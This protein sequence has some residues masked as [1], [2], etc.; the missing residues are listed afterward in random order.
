MNKIRVLIVDD[1]AVVRQVLTRELSK[2]PDIEVVGTAPDPYVA[3]DKIIQLLPDVLTLDIEMPRMDGLTFLRK[4]MRSKPIPTIVVSSLTPKGSDMAMDALDAG[5]VDVICKSG[6]AYSIGEVAATLIE[7]IR[8]AARVDATRLKALKESAMAVTKPLGALRKTTNQIFAIGA[9][10]GGTVAT[11]VLMRQLPSNSPGI[12]IVQHMPESFTRSYAERL[13]QLSAV[14]VREAK[15]GDRVIPGLAL[16]APGNF[17]MRLVRDGA[18]YAVKMDQETRLHYQRPAV[19]PLFDSVAE[20]AGSNCVAALLTG[21]GKDG[22][23]G[24]LRI[25]QAGGRTIAQD[26]NSSVVWGMPGEAVRLGAADFV[27]PLDQIA[28]KALSL[29]EKNSSFSE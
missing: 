26:E 1:S 20:V 17:H 22:A 19:D 3:R 18:V 21:M 8:A 10:T 15:N 6:A 7:Q 14:E 16:V 24:L 29:V 9:S 13:N 12:L 27:L 11:E 25:Q 23:Q 4:L 5:A 2:A 28:A